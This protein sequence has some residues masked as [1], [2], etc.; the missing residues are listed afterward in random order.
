MYYLKRSSLTILEM[1]VVV[2]PCYEVVLK[3]TFDDLMK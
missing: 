1:K 2:Y 3:G